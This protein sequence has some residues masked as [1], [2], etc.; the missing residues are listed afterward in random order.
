MKHTILI[1]AMLFSVCAFAQEAPSVKP[2][3]KVVRKI[4]ITHA[5][6]MLIALLL[7]GKLNLTSAP[8]ISTVI[9]K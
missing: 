7:S 9:K 3:T 4:K 8:E 6:P 2:D 5:D 1:F